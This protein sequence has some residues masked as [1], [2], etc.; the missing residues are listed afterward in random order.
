M[1]LD[2]LYHIVQEHKA[3]TLLSPKGFEMSAA[4]WRNLLASVPLVESEDQL[5]SLWGIPVQMHESIPLNE[6]KP[7]YG[8]TRV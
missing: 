4:T 8:T 2:E 1:D 6:I 7:V 5:D 3:K